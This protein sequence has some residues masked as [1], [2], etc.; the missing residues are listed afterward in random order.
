MN[1]EQ[2]TAEQ[3]VKAKWPD[4]VCDLLCADS[5]G[6]VYQVWKSS[7]DIS[8]PIGRGAKQAEAWKDAAARL[9]AIRAE[10]TKGMK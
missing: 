2:M 10:L 5:S 1:T 4:A 3:I 6:R 9:S 8:G 7:T